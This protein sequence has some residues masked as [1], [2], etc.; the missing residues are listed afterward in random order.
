MARYAET[1]SGMNG[2]K[3]SKKHRHPGEGRTKAHGALNARRAARRVSEA[4]HP[5]APSMASSPGFRPSPE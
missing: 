1:I 3:L 5:A 4:N 2:T